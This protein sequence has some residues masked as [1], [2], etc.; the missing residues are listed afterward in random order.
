MFPRQER[1]YSLSFHYFSCLYLIFYRVPINLR[2]NSL[3]LKFI[4]HL[5]QKER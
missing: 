2:N 4:K 1:L 5:L 3:Q